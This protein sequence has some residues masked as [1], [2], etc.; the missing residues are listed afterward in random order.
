L[1]G[2]LREI[3]RKGSPQDLNQAAVLASWR[4]P[5]H[6]QRGGD[7]SNPAKV[8][9]RLDSGHQIN[10]NDQAVL[11]SWPTSMAGTP[12]QKGYNEAGNTDSSRKTVALVG[13]WITPQTHDD[14]E[15]G[16]TEADHHYSPHDLSNQARLMDFGA[17]PTGSPAST[18]NRGQ[19][20]PAHSRWLMGLP[21]AWDECGVLI[22]LKTKSKRG[23]SDIKLT[24]DKHCETCGTVF[25]RKR[26]VSG[27]LEDVTA[28]EKRRFCSL[29]C[30]NSQVKGGDSRSAMNVQARKNLKFCCESC[31][32]RMSLEI[33]HVDENWK[34]NLTEN[35]QTL[36]RSCH[37]SWHIMQRNLGVVPAGR[38]PF[39]LSP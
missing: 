16:N 11:A 20:N 2:S 21:R 15:R 25:N 6:N 39:N 5:D 28:Y 33:H 3:E 22:P 14:K 35:L 31:G 24:L 36:C 32:S 23:R 10:L 30:A 27:A 4:T 1:E 12:A 17:K 8:L 34:N 13:H 29:S 26:F 9:K 38:K 19:L 18:G 7:Y 37:R